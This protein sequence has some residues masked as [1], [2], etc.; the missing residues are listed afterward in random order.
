MVLNSST[1]AITSSMIGGEGGYQ[2]QVLIQDNLGAQST[3]TPIFNIT[4]NNAT[5][6]LPWTGS[7]FNTNISAL[8]VDTS[9]AAAV[10][11]AYAGA[12]IRPL[13]GAAGGGGGI[14]FL[15]VPYNQGLVDVTTILYQ[16][17]FTQGPWPWYA[18]I[19]DNTVGHITG[20][21]NHSLIIQSAGGGNE[22]QLWEMWQGFYTGTAGTSGPWYDDSNFYL[23]NISSTGAGAYAMPPQGQGSADVAGLPIAPLLVNADEVIGSGTPS[24]PTGAVQHP[25]RFTVN[26]LLNY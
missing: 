12:Y 22:C 2:V 23:A 26:N 19:E 1:G 17:T 6:C 5:S 4:G 9:P 20:Q 7:I 13:F 25:I 14:P 21:D 10:Y 15:V 18:P 11:S 24:A 3:V 8:P 16:S